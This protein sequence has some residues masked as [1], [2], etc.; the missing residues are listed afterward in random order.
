[1]RHLVIRNLGSLAEADVYLERMNIV[2]GPQCSGK[3]SLLKSASY[4]SWVEKRIQLS[5]NPDQFKE[6]GYFEKKFVEFHKLAGYTS[7]DTFLMY[8][9]DTMAFS[10]SWRSGVFDFE[11]KGNRWEYVCP[12]VSYIPSERNI[13]AAIPNWFEVSLG[14]NNI[15]GFMKDWEVARSYSGDG[16][17]ILNMGVKYRF[18][19]GS[20]KDKVVLDN[21]ELL[22]FTDT[23][24]GLQ[25]LI[26][27]MT[28]LNYIYV[29]RFEGPT[30]KSV[31]R[32]QEEENLM[33]SLYKKEFIDKGLIAKIEPKYET[34]EN[35]EN[36]FVLDRLL[37]QVNDKYLIFDKKE[38]IE[39]FDKIFKNFTG[40]SVNDV[41]LEEP[42]LNL[43]PPTQSLLVDTL[44]DFAK[45]RHGG[46][47]FVATHSPY[48]V[49]SFIEKK[50]NSGVRLFLSQSSDNG[51]YVIRTAS[52][53]DVQQIYDYNI[54]IFHNIENIK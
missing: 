41:F 53:E 40:M 30:E 4:C 2:V 32:E 15:R 49:T 7:P 6:K 21:G 54:D 46:V 43:F 51:K 3:S 37:H 48:V 9:N 24:S 38:D 23:S 42:E 34:G 33:N 36:I 35:G 16:L 10:Y 25:S 12:K 39:R 5:Q 19:S 47:L 29:A 14:D 27:L 44:V 1:M 20:R 8:E 22:E 13:V 50:D 28:Y 18:D 11:W 52:G 26:P 45:S 17:P 31:S